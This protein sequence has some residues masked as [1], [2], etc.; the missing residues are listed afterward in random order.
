MAMRFTQLRNRLV[1]RFI[2]QSIEKSTNNKTYLDL[3]DVVERFQAYADQNARGIQVSP[4]LLTEK[5]TEVFGQCFDEGRQRFT[6]LKFREVKPQV[7]PKH[8]KISSKYMELIPRF[9][10][11]LSERMPHWW[12][13]NGFNA[14][15]FASF[16]KSELVNGFF[17]LA[18]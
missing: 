10:A 7:W 5:V 3:L 1:A 2:T 15:D 18:A 13:D 11:F 12:R 17:C 8:T 14:S 16:S 9:E 6:G 4:S